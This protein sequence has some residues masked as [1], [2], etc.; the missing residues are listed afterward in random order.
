MLVS[1]SGRCAGMPDGEYAL[2]G[3]SITMTGGKACLSGTDTLACSSVSLLECVRRAVFFGI[4][5]ED[6]V[7]AAS[8]APARVIGAEKAGSIE[9]GH[10]A[11]LVVLDEQLQVK[12]VYVDGERVEV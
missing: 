9:V 12:A 11:D 3:Q 1:D 8:T 4:P 10:S 2:G 6:A 7:Y 5:L